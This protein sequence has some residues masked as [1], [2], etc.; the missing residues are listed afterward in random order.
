MSA[1]LG[2]VCGLGS[3]TKKNT[4]AMFMAIRALEPAQQCGYCVTNMLAM[5]LRGSTDHWIAM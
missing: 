3:K 4:V 2:R 1:S 5:L